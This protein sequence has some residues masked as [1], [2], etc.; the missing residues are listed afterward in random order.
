MFQKGAVDA[1]KEM[2]IQAIANKLDI[3]KLICYESSKTIQIA[4]FG[5]S[6]GPNTFFAMQNI[7]EAVEQKYQAMHGNSETIDLEF[8]VFFNDHTSNDFNT[9]FKSLPL[10][11]PYF[12]AGVPGS[13]YGRLF[14]QSSI[15]IGHSSSALQW[16][17]K[18][19][20]EVVDSNSPAYN[21]GS[22]YCT[23]TEK[24]VS[25]AFAAQ[26]ENDMGTFLNARAEELVSGGLIVLLTG[27]IPNGISLI[28]TS[29]GKFYDFFGSCLLDLAK[30]VRLAG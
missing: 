27:G 13:F 5:C 10:S 16:L 28:Q 6:V 8:Q 30:K 7:I 1:T 14:P 21:K 4:D 12:A 15:H 25:K 29:I 17:S 22:I 23:G 26:F 2:I 3:E 9:L 18:V 11:R 19:P 24:E 20:E